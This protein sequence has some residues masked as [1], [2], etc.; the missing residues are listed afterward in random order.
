MGHKWILGGDFNAKHSSWGSRLTSPQGCVLHRASQCYNCHPIST[1]S[2]TYWP[3]DRDKLLNVIDFFLAKGVPI[4]HTTA[5]CI[6]DLGSDHLPL[7][8]TVSNMP[9]SVDISRPLTNKTTDWDR[10]RELVHNQLDLKVQLQSPEELDQQA[11]KFTSVL[12]YCVQQCTTYSTSSHN[13]LNIP[14]LSTL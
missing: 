3:T 7:I 12:C 13:Q 10:Y 1:G 4:H 9:V 11:E 8:L 14:H 5:E 2:P 6:T